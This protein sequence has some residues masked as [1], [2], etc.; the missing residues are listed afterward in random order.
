MVKNIGNNGSLIY[1]TVIH[2]RADKGTKHTIKM[3]QNIYSTNNIDNS[4]I[5][6]AIQKPVL[7]KQKCRIG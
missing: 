4:N 7:V 1:N 6:F 2:T 5:Y 3:D